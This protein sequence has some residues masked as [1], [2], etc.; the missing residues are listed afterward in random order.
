MADAVM[1]GAKAGRVTWQARE[2]E[3]ASLAPI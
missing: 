3:E 1:V 2:P